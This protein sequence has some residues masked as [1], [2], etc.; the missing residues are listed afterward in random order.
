M[1]SS[2][3]VPYIKCFSYAELTG[4]L[5]EQVRDIFSVAS[6]YLA[7]QPATKINSIESVY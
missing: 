4:A 3:A 6:E 2:M 7:F 1:R 5:L